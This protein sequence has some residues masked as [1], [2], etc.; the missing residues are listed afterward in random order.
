MKKDHTLTLLDCTLRDGGYLNNWNF[1]EKAIAD[2][3]HSISNTNVDIIEIGFLKDEP[4]NKNRTVFNSMGQVK[5]I[6][7]K[8]E[9]NI[10]Y[11]VMCEVVNPIPLEKI[12]PRDEE[13]ADIIRVI[14]WKTKRDSEGNTIDALQEGFDYCKGIVEKGYKL[15]VQPARVDQ[16]SENEFIAM[17]NKFSMLNPLAI[18]VVDSWGTQTP[19]K[20]IKYMHMAD[21]N[22]PSNIK[23]GYHGHNNLLQALP[24]A[25]M[26][27]KENFKRD[28]MIDASIFGIG[29]GAGN[30]NLELIMKYLNEEY[31]TSYNLDE[32]VR[33]NEQYLKKIYETEKWG[34]SIQYYLTAKYNCNPAYARRFESIPADD[35]ESILKKLNDTDRIIFKK[36]RSDEIYD[37]YIQNSNREEK[38]C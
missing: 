12:E 20:L 36:S 19:E 14:V 8:K 24:T 21:D 10:E 7:G 35:F 34:Y 16:Y 31:N 11:A 25:Q 27:I 33:L 9:K 3:V 26:M 2:M 30:L 32:L 38:T 18:Y 1:G 13:S 17:L 5:N 15:C 37:E 29:R 22:L 28:I 23:I 6:I 4:Y